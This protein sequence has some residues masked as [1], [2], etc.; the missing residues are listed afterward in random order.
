MPRSPI[1]ALPV[2]KSGLHDECAVGYVE[3]AAFD[4]EDR[5]ASL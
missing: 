2:V 1:E 3:M 4:I 5:Q